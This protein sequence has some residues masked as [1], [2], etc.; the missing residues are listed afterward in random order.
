MTHTFFCVFS[1]AAAAAAAAA[2]F[3]ARSRHQC[4]AHCPCCGACRPARWLVGV[5]PPCGR[6]SARAASPAPG[7]P[8]PTLKRYAAAIGLRRRCSG[9]PSVL[10][11]PAGRGRPPGPL[12][13]VGAR[14]RPR[15]AGSGPGLRVVLAR[16]AP[17]PRGA[18]RVPPSR[19]LGSVFR[20]P[21]RV[22]APARQ[23]R[24]PMGCAPRRARPRLGASLARRG[25]PTPVRAAAGGSPL[26][27]PG[28]P[29]AP[30]YHLRAFFRFRARSFC[31]RSS[32]VSAI[33]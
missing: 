18:R 25:R 7:S 1:A 17:P 26:Y 13:A 20:L 24:A 12:P 33:A 21:A 31:L 3:G 29:F 10:P 14:R 5:P 15:P 16:P 4:R 9:G 11:R 30:K 19:A 28:V 6:P 27:A 2:I 23:G 8:R 32:K 22:G